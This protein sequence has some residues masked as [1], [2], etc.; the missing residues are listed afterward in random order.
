MIR[1]ESTDG[2]TSAV[3]AGAS[4]DFSVSHKDIKLGDKLAAGAYGEVFAATWNGTKV[5]VKRMYLQGV[6]DKAIA[7]FKHE[8]EI[9]HQMRHPNLVLF[10]GACLEMPHMYQVQEFCGRG[11]LYG[12]YTDLTLKQSKRHRFQDL[13][14]HWAFCLSFAR[15]IS[16]GLIYL[17]KRDIPIL[18]RDLKST[19]VLMDASEPR[20]A[21]H[22]P[23]SPS[24]RRTVIYL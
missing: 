8:A 3:K 20:R 13:G 6:N 23:P 15:D 4:W 18:H 12:M 17:H 14:K 22:P 1:L 10:M 5:A 16:K 24:P 21:E 2:K 19:N 7:E 9:M 11:S